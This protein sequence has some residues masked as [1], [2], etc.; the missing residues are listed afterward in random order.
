M[1]TDTKN[2]ELGWQ[3]SQGRWQMSQQCVTGKLW[4]IFRVPVVDKRTISIHLG[5]EEDFRSKWL[6]DFSLN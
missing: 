5:D 4:K 2:R 3:V 1:Q 6:F